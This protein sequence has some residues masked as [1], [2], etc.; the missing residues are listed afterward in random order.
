MASD[1]EELDANVSLDNSGIDYQERLADLDS[2]RLE[3]KLKKEELD[4]R[5]EDRRLRKTL[6]E[7]IYTFATLYMF[8][9]MGILLLCGLP[10]NFSLTE[11]VLI[12]L[13][14]TTTANVIGVLMVV[15]TYYFYR[16]KK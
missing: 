2:K 4:G 16:T 5:K 11:N 6:S 3:N 14:G 8:A 12:T 9:I 10:I 7:R 15:A 1:I 13:L